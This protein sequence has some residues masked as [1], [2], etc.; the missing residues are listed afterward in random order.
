M[1]GKGAL[2][3]LVREQ[4]HRYHDAGFHTIEASDHLGLAKKHY[5]VN[6]ITMRPSKYDLLPG[7]DKLFKDVK[8]KQSNS[9][10]EKPRYNILSGAPV[11]DFV[12]VKGSSFRKRSMLLPR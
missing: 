7:N 6:T 9:R 8:P 5:N 4:K 10:L 3:S 2:V 12:G 1:S 11:H